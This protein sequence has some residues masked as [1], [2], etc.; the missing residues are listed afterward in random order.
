MV[1]NMDRARQAGDHATVATY[2]ICMMKLSAA[3]SGP[4]DLGQISD[5]DIRREAKLLI[6]QALA[7]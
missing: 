2:T 6:Q 3:I 1:A 7:E 4:V 5:E